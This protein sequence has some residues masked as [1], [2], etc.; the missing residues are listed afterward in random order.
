[1]KTIII[2]A[3]LLFN[4]IF[5]QAQQISVSDLARTARFNKIIDEVNN[6]PKKLKYSEIQGTPYYFA[7][8]VPARVG[9]TSGIIPIRYSPF[10]DSVEILDSNT[11]NVYELPKEAAYPKF[12]FETTHEKLVL[13]NTHNEYSGY[14]FELVGGKN[15]LLKKVITTFKNETPPPN[16]LVPGIPAKFEIQRPIYFIKT[17]DSVIKLSKKAD[18]LLN[19]LPADK[20]DATKDFIKT[21]KIK[22]NEELDLIKLVTFLNK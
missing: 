1:M 13:I 8:F 7:N 10:L 20:K 6:G 11:G 4:G 17:E 12:T 22:L 2:T 16:T 18:D 9:D 19:A 15:K 21:N 3:S 14:F 5:L